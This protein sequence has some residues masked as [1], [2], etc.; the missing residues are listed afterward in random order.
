[1]RSVAGSRPS[2]G[3][4]VPLALQIGALVRAD[5]AFHAVG[6][7]ANPTRSVDGA[8]GKDPLLLVRRLLKADPV[9]PP[10][11]LAVDRLPVCVGLA[12]FTLAKTLGLTF[13][14]L[15][16]N[17]SVGVVSERWCWRGALGLLIK[18]RA[19]GVVG[20]A[21]LAGPFGTVVFGVDGDLG[22]ALLG[23]LLALG[24]RAGRSP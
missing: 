17:L 8:A 7:H 14:P 13:Q 20:F 3:V 12:V 4:V 22:E 6:G 16:L 5:H 2:G 23:F 24:G 9:G 21:V 10:D 15:P 11:G 19:G 1:M 18:T